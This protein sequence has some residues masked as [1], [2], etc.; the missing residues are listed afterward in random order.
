LARDDKRQLLRQPPKQLYAWLAGILGCL[1]SFG[2]GARGILGRLF[3]WI[4]GDQGDAALN[5]WILERNL[6]YGLQGGQGLNLTALFTTNT[7]WPETN[8]LAW[9]DNWLALTPVYSLLRLAAPPGQAFALLITLCIS[10]NVAACY[11][12]C[13]H[14]TSRSGDRLLAACLA[15]FSLTM[16]ARLGHAQL[17]PAFA[18]VLAIDAALAALSREAATGVVDPASNP[19]AAARRAG[20]PQW[21]LLIHADG[22]LTAL[23]WLLL[24]LAIGFYQGVFFAVASAC[25]LAAVLCQHWMTRGTVLRFTWCGLTQASQ[26]TNLVLR[27]VGLGVL[28]G[29][30]GVI[31]R[32]YLLF[33][34]QV[35]RRPWDEVASMIPKVWSFGFNSL[36]NPGS[37]SLPAPIQSIDA[38]SYPGAFW[39][40]SLFPGYTYALLLGLGIWLGWRSLK[41]NGEGWP[42]PL[43]LLGQTCL[44]MLVVSLGIGGRHQL[45]TAWA[46]LYQWV[47]GFSALRAVSRI[48]LPLVLLAAPILAWT[49]AE[50][51]SRLDRQRRLAV[52]ATLL[53]LYVAGNVITPGVPR[54][55]S[56]PY[57][58]RVKTVSQR[59]GRLVRKGDC[60]A[61]YLAASTQTLPAALDSQLMAMWASL[62]TGYPTVSGYSGHTPTDGW[63]AHMSKDE[64]RN[65]LRQRGL[66]DRAVASVC[67]IP[68]D[69]VF[70]RGV[71]KPDS[72]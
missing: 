27:L 12:L 20:A 53:A 32:Q 21:R 60:R 51:Q 6:Q 11:R 38:T 29:L 8:T 2:L 40:H 7:F 26:R 18:G 10:A 49:L 64:L 35:G 14:A 43:M 59:V 15:G 22:A 1:F 50:L 56:R 68:A 16:L 52:L 33:S 39:E 41:A 63:T 71:R 57:E 46:V 4:P 47:P 61:F 54:F 48:G 17:M 70:D 24:Q 42:W 69:R 3:T 55:A 9:S 34:R 13:R 62:R 72:P 36:S 25:L 65:W 37:V 44:L 30:N 23:L 31:Y 28:V 45:I 19:S 67:W 66:D 58:A 5:N